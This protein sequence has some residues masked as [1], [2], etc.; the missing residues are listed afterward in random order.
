[1]FGNRYGFQ[2]S[3][4]KYQLVL[5]AGIQTMF[6]KVH[7]SIVR[8]LL[9]RQGDNLLLNWFRRTKPMGDRGEFGKWIK[10]SKLGQGVPNNEF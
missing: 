5:N 3:M 6:S 4:E 10:L 2:M 8:V 9:L 1:M 7:V